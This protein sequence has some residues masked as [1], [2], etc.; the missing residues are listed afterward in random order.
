M[1]AKPENSSAD[2]IEITPEMIEAGY[3]VLISSGV[4]DDPLEADRL[5][6]E[7]IYRAMRRVSLEASHKV[8]ADL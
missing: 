5:W 6:V 4:T 3:R 1:C 8:P 7:E 2:E